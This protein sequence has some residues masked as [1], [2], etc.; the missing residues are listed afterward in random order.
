LDQEFEQRMIAKLKEM[1]FASDLDTIT[2][3]EVGDECS[4][5]FHNQHLFSPTAQAGTGAAL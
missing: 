5:S 3:K 1:M 4:N 2:S